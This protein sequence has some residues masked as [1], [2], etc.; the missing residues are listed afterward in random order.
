MP[1]RLLEQA[2]LLRMINQHMATIDE[3]R[4]IEAISIAIAPDHPNGANW[5]IS[6]F[7]H[8]GNEDQVD[9]IDA[10]EPFV[11]SLQSRF[12]MHAG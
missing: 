2:D 5:A 8:R 9:C 4:N 7:R 3:C 11:A 6:G 10:I 1:R 12:D